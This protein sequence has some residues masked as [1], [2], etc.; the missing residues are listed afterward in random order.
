[1]GKICM[2]SLRK[3]HKVPESKSEV[4]QAVSMPR[5]STVLWPKRSI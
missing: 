2:D 3:R 4:M 1:M 5:A